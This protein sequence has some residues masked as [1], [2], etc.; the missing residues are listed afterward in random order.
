MQNICARLLRANMRRVYTARSFKYFD[1]LVSFWS[2]VRKPG[3]VVKVVPSSNDCIDENRKNC[4]SLL[5]LILSQEFY[6]TR[7]GII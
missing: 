7:D 1:N 4:L 6:Y 3:L 5:M 2:K